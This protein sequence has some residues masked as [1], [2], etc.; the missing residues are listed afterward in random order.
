MHPLRDV[1]RCGCP[2]P[3]RILTRRITRH[4]SITKFEGK[5]AEVLDPCESSVSSCQAAAQQKGLL[6]R[7]TIRRRRCYASNHSS[8]HQPSSDL[9]A[10]SLTSRAVLL[11]WLHPTARCSHYSWCGGC[12]APSCSNCRK[13]L[14]SL[15]LNCWPFQLLLHLLS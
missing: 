2:L 11:L 9:G 7:R 13:R 4:Q 14:A 5:K 8:H 6:P 15:G 1:S 3:V 12:R 10:S